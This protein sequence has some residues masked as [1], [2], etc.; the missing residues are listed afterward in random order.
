MLAVAL[1]HTARNNIHLDKVIADEI[2]L[3]L[4]KKLSSG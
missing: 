4:M 3:S 2:I 1:K